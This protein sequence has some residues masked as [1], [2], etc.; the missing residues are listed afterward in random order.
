MEAIHWVELYDEC[1]ASIQGFD[2]LQAYP[3]GDCLLEQEAFLI[4]VFKVIKDEK[5]QMMQE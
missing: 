4:K 1:H 3:D 5:L 2:I